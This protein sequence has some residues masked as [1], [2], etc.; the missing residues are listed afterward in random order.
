MTFSKALG[1]YGG[2]V[3]GPAWLRERIVRQ[4]HAF[5]GNTPLP[6]P[7]AAAALE[8]L[9]MIEQGKPMRRRL[10][11]SIAFVKTALRAGGVVLPDILVPIITLIAGGDAGVKRVRRALLKRNIY[12]NFISYPGLP[13]GGCFRFVVSSE[14][15]RT[16][17]SALLEVL[18]P[19]VA[20]GVLRTASPG[21][22]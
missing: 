18:V 5:A 14:H 1:V 2:A 17:L 3:L 6:L 15:R 22:S 9:K 13:S 16:H 19:F 10:R 20:G 8:A 12:P 4:S 21:L 7:L 11:T